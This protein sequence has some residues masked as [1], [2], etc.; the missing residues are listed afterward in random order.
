MQAEIATMPERAKPRRLPAILPWATLPAVVFLTLALELALAER[1]FA[2]FGGGFGQS[3]AVDTPFETAVFFAALLACQALLFYLFYRLMRR[4]HGRKADTLLF[5]FNFF[6]FA[7]LTATAVL[8]AKYQAL[9]YFSDALSFQIV[10][11]LGGG[12]LVEAALYSLSEAGL[13]LLVVAGG[14]AFYVLALLVLRRRWRDAPPLPDRT[15]LGRRQ[16]AAALVATPLLV[17][18][19]SQ[20]EDVR[21]GLSRFNAWFLVSAVLNQATDFDRDGYSLFSHP[22]DTHMFDGSRHP[23]ALDIPNNGIDEDGFAG[24][25]VLPEADLAAQAAAP[26]RIIGARPH[27]ILVVLE[28]T[29]GDAL[30]HRVAGRAVV[31]HLEALA[32]D[33]M[34]VPHAYS[35]VG[36]TSD[37]MQN[38]FTGRLAPRGRTPSLFED[39][40]ES[41]YRIGV[42]SA[43]AE[44]FGNIAETVQMRRADIYVDA[45]VLRE[46]R[47]FSLG[48][49]SSL[50]L[51]GR[52]LLRE[53]DRHFGRPEQWQRPNFLYV[54]FQ[55]AH[56]PYSFPGM[57][58]ILPGEPIARS[59]IG[60]ANK[61]RVAAAYWNAVAYNDRLLGE[62]VARL[63]RLGV[64][65]NSLIVVTGDHGEALFEE[66]FLGHG[67]MISREQTHI[68]FVLS[69]PVPVAAPVGLTDMR[70]IILRAAGAD[71]PPQRGA[72][73]GRVF[74]YI[75][76]L[77]RPS[78]IGFAMGEAGWTIF[79]FDREAL[80][81]SRAPR[82]QP[83]A[84]LAPGSPARREADELITEWGRQRWLQAAAR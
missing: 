1:K 74:Q 65:D 34:S 50:N 17:F 8:F 40:Q 64:Y 67:H 62:L 82:W 6:Y 2:V 19:A 43:M 7:T 71:A 48:S 9:S 84:D 31:P 24:D 68:P 13:I 18:G 27:V 29:R 51:D 10:R 49:V 20:I 4:L 58:R 36:F 35:H 61:D 60:P 30:G 26:V 37:S 47:V 77:D 3:R 81:T 52:T 21:S 15:R 83:Y 45:Q 78:S 12:S 38:L 5:H 55:S 28:S 59:E 11:N 75:G 69:R 66:G 76:S 63:R 33:G 73:P 16:F 72:T 32:A 25:L 57:D 44:D 22:R 39:F 23:F 14:I 53:F 79:S 70:S 46:E 56:F 42:F 80:W 41:G 54:N